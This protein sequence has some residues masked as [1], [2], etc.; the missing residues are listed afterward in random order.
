MVSLERA[1]IGYSYSSP[2]WHRH[3]GAFNYSEP[4]MHEPAVEPYWQRYQGR[5]SLQPGSCVR[6]RGERA[7]ISEIYRDGS[8]LLVYSGGRQA[9]APPEAVQHWLEDYPEHASTPPSEPQTPAYVPDVS[10]P[11]DSYAREAYAREPV[12]HREPAYPKEVAYPA[13]PAP[14]PAQAARE[15]KP[16][17]NNDGAPPHA[18]RTLLVAALPLHATEQDLEDLF[19]MFGPVRKASLMVTGNNVSRCFGFVKFMEHESALAAKETADR[20]Q[21]GFGNGNQI[22]VEWAR[23]EMSGRQARG[24]RVV[25][26]RAPAAAAVQEYAAPAEG[27]RAVARAPAHAGYAAAHMGVGWGPRPR[28]V[29]SRTPSPEV[30]VR[31]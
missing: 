17:A 4:R 10:Y 25:K 14:A 2:D 21:L 7:V 28:R 20:G 16:A 6:I 12:Y 3:Y 24:Q 15:A 11:P 29:P 5:Y 22:R 13:P 19:A 26:K 30:G 31:W 1:P 18:M 9:V 8:C 23:R 27:H